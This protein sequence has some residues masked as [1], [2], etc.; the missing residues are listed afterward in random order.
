MTSRI[1]HFWRRCAFCEKRAA[2]VHR[3][4]RWWWPFP[5]DTMVCIDH[6]TELQINDIEDEDRN[7]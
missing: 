7:A 1:I 2:Y 3:V 4:E 6:A 5:K